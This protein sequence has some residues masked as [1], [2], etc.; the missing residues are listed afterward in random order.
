MIK[1]NN[2]FN[3]NSEAKK[4]TN[5]NIFSDQIFKFSPAALVYINAKGKILDISKSACSLFGYSEPSD[6][7]GK[8][9][10]KLIHHSLC[11]TL[12]TDINNICKL[13]TAIEYQLVNK[14][15]KIFNALLKASQ[16][17]EKVDTVSTFL[18]SF[19][20]TTATNNHKSTEEYLIY[21][22]QLLDRT[23]FASCILDSKNKMKYMNRA[24]TEL[25]GY[26]KKDFRDKT[27]I[28][29]VYNYDK[30]LVLEHI[31]KLTKTEDSISTNV[32]LLTK[33]KKKIFVNLSGYFDSSLKSNLLFI[34][35]LSPQHQNQE[36]LSY[37][38]R[39]RNDIFQAIG[40]PAFILDMNRTIL[41]VNNAT[42]KQT[43]LE[44]HQLIGS[45]CYKIFHKKNSPPPGCPFSK[46]AKNKS[47]LTA[48]MKVEFL[49]GY[50]LVSCTPIF[51]ADNKVSKMIH[52]ATDITELK[53][54]T[55]KLKQNEEKFRVMF[56]NTGTAICLIDDNDLI[57]TCNNTFSNLVNIPRKKIQNIII[58]TS[59]LK[60]I[61]N[62]QSSNCR[63][64]TKKV[65]CFK[66]EL[67][68]SENI[69]KKV[70]VQI[71][72]FKNDGYRIVSIV[73]ITP[74]VKA[75]DQVISQL[76]EKELLLKEV[77]HRVK[78][79]LQI[80]S[81]LLSLQHRTIA[82]KDAEYVFF[83]IQTR[84]RSIALVHEELYRSENLSQINFY[85]YVTNLTRYLL[86]T[87]SS[88]SPYIDIILNT[89]VESLSID[90]T[91]T[92]GLILNE[93]ITNSLKYAFPDNLKKQNFISID[94]KKKNNYTLTV[95]DNGIGIP[96][97]I[98]I[99]NTN[100]LGLRLINIL[101]TDQLNGWVTISRIKGTTFEIVF[102]E[103]AYK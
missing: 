72:R 52:I 23:D 17:P 63:K 58:L 70:Y 49:N 51:N 2:I 10:C 74:L 24:F 90:K 6:L 86:Q 1:Q 66:G 35:D 64:K 5:P 11:K 27:F 88:F 19:T 101:V 53:K 15:G 9:I 67:K 39:E 54:T 94:L 91:I 93:I 21:S 13:E 60:N 71:S 57:V 89:E 56:E 82:Q 36:V 38:S 41:E 47:L 68:T 99:K 95:K 45:K 44:E 18:L 22:R 25:T 69:I 59:V 103:H 31:K 28:E 79:N 65:V 42:L 48:E 92:C 40:Q 78:N 14:N 55:D 96:D 76:K 46:A 84:I 85:N 16:L 4:E 8:N 100:S 3:K 29:I 30:K 98:D 33:S 80:I 102:P 43:G 34:H 75:E 97:N 32:V 7:S 81:S 83:D 61:E 73:D 50:Y 62:N 20:K 26:T 12:L 87:M 37:L 77:H